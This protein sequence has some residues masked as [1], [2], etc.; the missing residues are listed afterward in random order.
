MMK[1]ANRLFIFTGVALALV[2]V[3][4][5][6]TMTGADK[7]TTAQDKPEKVKVV[8]AA[9]DVGPHQ[10]LSSADIVVEEVS[11]D[12]VPAGVVSD[13]SLV[14][15]QA[16]TL[17]AA[18]GDYLLAV[19]LQAP[20]LANQIADGKRAFSLEVDS[21]QMMAGLVTEGDH[22]DLV[23]DA[24]VDINRILQVQGVEIMEDGDYVLKDSPNSDDNNSDDDNNNDDSNN[25][26]A[27]EGLSISDGE[28]AEYQGKPGTEFT[29]TDAGNNLEPVTKLMIQDVK[30]LRVV[31]PGTEFDPQGQQV[32]GAE[33]NTQA[34]D[35]EL[36]LLIL[37]VTPQQAEAIS[38]MQNNPDDQYL[39]HD[40]EV[41]VRAL[42]DHEVAN[43]SGI[44]FQIL[45]TDDTWSLPWPVPI[46]APEAEA[47]EE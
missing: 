37:E 27:S 47:Q 42:D 4:L 45:M 39:Y 44:T 7:D 12:E 20:G 9:V 31:Q 23:F 14:I 40:V 6:I 16:Y 19:Y 36:G 5:G 21:Q 33:S 35:G 25:D 3:L 22:V 15:G 1:G 26:E 11:A 18:K 41:I 34:N 24:R 2:A 17:G 28:S 8:K 30:V 46:A 29:I 13:T 10:V 32:Q 38:F 43:T